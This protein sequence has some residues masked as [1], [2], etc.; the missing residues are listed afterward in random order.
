DRTP[1]DCP[2]REAAEQPARKRQAWPPPTEETVFPDGLGLES[3]AAVN[4]WQSEV[5][6]NVTLKADGLAVAN[7]WRE[8]PLMHCLRG[9]HQQARIPTHGPDDF[10]LA[11]TGYDHI[12]YSRSLHGLGIWD[13]GVVWFDARGN[14]IEGGLFRNHDRGCRRRIGIR[15]GRLLVC[16]LWPLRCDGAGFISFKCVHGFRHRRSRRC[17]IQR[18]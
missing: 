6:S 14:M 5:E 16:L 2:M 13:D 15:G 9:R 7:E 11:I 3:A 4:S 8:T 18:I 17:V 1:G 12:H 10:D